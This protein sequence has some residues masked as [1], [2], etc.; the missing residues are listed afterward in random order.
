[1]QD[2][3]LLWQSAGGTGP[4]AAF[5]HH[6]EP[7][8]LLQGGHLRLG[9]CH[10]LCPPSPKWAVSRV[11][12]TQPFALFRG[13][14]SWA[15]KLGSCS[16]DNPWNPSWGLWERGR[17]RATV[18]WPE[19]GGGGRLAGWKRG[20]PRPAAVLPSS[21]PG[22]LS[23]KSPPLFIAQAAWRKGLPVP[24]CSSLTFRTDRPN[25]A[26][27]LPGREAIAWPLPPRNPLEPSFSSTNDNE[28][29]HGL[30]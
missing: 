6:T 9:G 30:A 21:R 16:S 14:A 28:R 27:V 13:W 18:A 20:Q 15:P 22:A 26:L 24:A 19:R 29:N 12:G 5:T 11:V 10:N 17:W 7:I 1:M 25:C 4:A 2:D 8:A 23:P 3:G